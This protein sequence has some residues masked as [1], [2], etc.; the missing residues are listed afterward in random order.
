MRDPGCVSSR[1]HAGSKGASGGCWLG[2][3]G[4]REETRAHSVVGVP[5][6]RRSFMHRDSA[7]FL[8]SSVRSCSTPLQRPNLR[9]DCWQETR[10]VPRPTSS[11]TS[12]AS[13][14][15]PLG[16]LAAAMETW[17]ENLDVRSVMPWTMSDETAV[18][19][20]ALTRLYR[21][22]R[23]RGEDNRRD[24]LRSCPHTHHS[25]ARGRGLSPGASTLT[26]TTRQ[27]TRQE[28]DRILDSYSTGY[29]G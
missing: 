21:A 18:K 10:N 25:N 12:L 14:P 20:K 23:G 19:V 4:M 26:S 9:F 27:E 3:R 16:A 5:R 7:V 29:S 24:G 2:S 22:G 28:L 8:V 1:A 17:M 11:P 15:A 13:A 6:S